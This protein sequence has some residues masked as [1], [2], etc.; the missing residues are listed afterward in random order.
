M[1]EARVRRL[2]WQEE[3][4]KSASNHSE[5]RPGKGLALLLCVQILSLIFQAAG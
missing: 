2:S 3:K 1:A 5:R 4:A